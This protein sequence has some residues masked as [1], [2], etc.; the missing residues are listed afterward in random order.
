MGIALE[1]SDMEEYPWKTA[2]RSL[3]AMYPVQSKQRLHAVSGCRGKETPRALGEA[4]P[5][6]AVIHKDGRE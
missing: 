6:E 4:S 1:N 3:K 2:F 5:G